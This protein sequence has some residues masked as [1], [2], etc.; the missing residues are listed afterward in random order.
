MFEKLIFWFTVTGPLSSQKN[1][2]IICK[3]IPPFLF[4]ANI[5]TLSTYEGNWLCRNVCHSRNWCHL[6]HT[7]SHFVLVQTSIWD[8]KWHFAVNILEIYLLCHEWEPSFIKTPYRIWQYGLSSF[9]GRD[10]KV[11]RFLAKNQ[12]SQNLQ[13]TNFQ[14]PLFSKTIF[15]KLDTISI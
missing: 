15:D 1:D 12:Q 2:W 14:R 4:F 13:K 10:T 6:P 5:E 3:R 7:E 9:L 11:D 8:I